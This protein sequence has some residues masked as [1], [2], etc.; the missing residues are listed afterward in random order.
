M[1]DDLGGG[2]R[3]TLFTDEFRTP[4]LVDDVV[5]I[6]EAIIRARVAGTFHLCGPQRISRYELGLL[7]SKAFALSEE[8]IVPTSRSTLA[9]LRPQDCSLVFSS[10][11]RQLPYECRGPAEGFSTMASN[12]RRVK[13]G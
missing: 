1:I 3:V 6:V 2:R 12:R 8:S 10:R 11:L 5:A 4:V 7:C 9:P 13:R